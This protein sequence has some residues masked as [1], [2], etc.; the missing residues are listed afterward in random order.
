VV[1]QG[2]GYERGVLHAILAAGRRINPNRL[3]QFARARGALAKNDRLD[4]R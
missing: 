3:R 4:A 2:G 1:L